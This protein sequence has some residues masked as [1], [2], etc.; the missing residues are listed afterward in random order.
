MIEWRA[1]D[2]FSIGDTEYVS[3]PV[4]GRYPSSPAR[5]CLLKARW[6]VEWYAKLLHDLAPQRMVEVGMYDGASLALAAELAH[7]G[8]LVGI[9]HRAT[10]STPLAEIIARRGWQDSVL[11]YHGV[12][13]ADASRV[14][15]IFDDATGGA[16]LKPV[17]DDASH[18]LEPSRS[19]FNTLFPWLA[20]GARY[21]LEDWPMHKAMETPQPLTVMV[22]E[23]VLAC[24]EAPGVV[25]DLELNRNDVVVTRG[26]ARLE[27]DSFDL[28]QR[29]GPRARALMGAFA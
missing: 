8:V 17:V 12:D 24:S 11:P 18:V 22:F 14:A 1:D 16:P 2:T 9:D 4:E 19:T 29:Y 25:A 3:R 23:L 6:Q 21:V 10:P 20:P 26:D 27:P 28:S 5:F 13:Q 15:Q 7:P